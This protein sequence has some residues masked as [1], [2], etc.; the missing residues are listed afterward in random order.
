MRI[1]GALLAAALAL[2]LGCGGPDIPSHSGYKSDK[3]K[4]WKKPKVIPLDEKGEGKV[5][6][7]LSYAEY[8]RAKWYAVDVPSEGQ[9]D[10]SLEISPPGD[11]EEY[12][13]AMEVL[14]P[15]FVVISKADLDEDDAHEVLKQRSLYELSPGR[16]LIHLY[17]ERRIDTGEYDLK[18]AFTAQAKAYESTFP[19]DVAFLPR[20]P[21]V[22]LLDDTPA[23]QIVKRTKPTIKRTGKGRTKTTASKPEDT[24]KKVNGHVINVVVSGSDSVITVDRGN[25]QGVSDGMKGYVVGVKDGGFSTS[26][27]TE[28]NCKGKVAATP[29]QISKAGGK[30]I[31]IA[32]P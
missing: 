32:S 31:L 14:D 19:A 10:V 22:P 8:R 4:P 24:S 15:N 3:A 7:E 25:A 16:Y 2:A 11:D 17:L 9:L 23:D 29:D 12:D 13:M 5:D 6:G 21:V 28:R 27:C 18:V 30:V 1:L 26:S 20:L